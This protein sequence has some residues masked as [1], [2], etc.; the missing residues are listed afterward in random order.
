MEGGLH[1]P[2]EEMLC[3]KQTAVDYLVNGDGSEEICT[4]SSALAL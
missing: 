3:N 4:E 1:G 2:D